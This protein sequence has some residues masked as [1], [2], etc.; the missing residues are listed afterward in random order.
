MAF[1]VS[2]AA[3]AK[4]IALTPVRHV[5]VPMSA[6]RVKTVKLYSRITGIAV[7]IISTLLLF[8]GEGFA[9]LGIAMSVTMGVLAVSLLAACIKKQI[10][11]YMISA[12][13]GRVTC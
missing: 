8:F 12:S 11:A 2:C 13:I 5:N 3:L 4:V 10:C 1:I 9:R 6:E 7:V